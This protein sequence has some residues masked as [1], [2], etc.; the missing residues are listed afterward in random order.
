MSFS[1]FVVVSDTINY[2]AKNV[3]P[4]VLFKVLANRYFLF[5]SCRGNLHLFSFL[6]FLLLNLAGMILF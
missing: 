3:R 6:N 4:C 5:F 1:I 2:T